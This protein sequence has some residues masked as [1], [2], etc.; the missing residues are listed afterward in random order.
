VPNGDL[1][2]LVLFGALFLFALAG[3]PLT[4]RRARRRLSDDWSALA[5]S[6]SILPFA[7]IIAGRAR[8]HVDRPMVL[9]LLLTALVAF[10][11]LSGGHA[12]L[13]RADPL[14][15]ALG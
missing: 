8:A 1:R 11:L 15:L 10:W 13:F 4:E 5:A 12:L 6:T 3:I 14:A 7:A 2:S 9:S